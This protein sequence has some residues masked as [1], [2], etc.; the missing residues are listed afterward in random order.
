MH[1]KKSVVLLLI[2]CMFLSSSAFAAQ[3]GDYT[4]TESGGN[5]TITAYTGAGGAISIP[6]TLGGYPTVAIGASAFFGKSTIT[7]VTI[8]DSVTSIGGQAFYNCSGMTSVSISASVISIGSQAFM[9]CS[10]LT[11]ITVDAGNPNYS[12][13]DDVLYNNP[14]TTLIQFPGGKSGAFIIPGSVTS[15]GGSAFLGCSYLTNVSISASVISIGSYAFNYCYALTTITVDAGNPNYSSLDGV[16]Y[17]NTRTTLIQFPGGKSGAFIIP[18]SVTSIVDYAF[19]GCNDMTIIRIPDS[20]TSIGSRAFASCTGLTG[21]NIPDS[22]TNIG[23]W[24]FFGCSNLTG[25]YF[26]GNAPTMGLNVFLNCSSGFTVYYLAGATGFTNPWYGYPTAVFT[27]TGSLALI[28]PNGGES[29][30]RNSQRVITWSASGCQGTL[31][32]T[33]WQNGGLIG[34][35]VDDVNPVSG[36]YSWVV[37]NYIGGTAP[38]G[39]GYAI[40]I[41]DN[42]SSLED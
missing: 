21:M 23:G 33:L 42:G 27:P 24:A 26:Y 28:K 1:L 20:V 2:G 37:G 3:D 11:T 22:V 34:T 36:S 4:Y 10:V 40:K 16:L 35:I 12:S 9:L 17:N 30:N 5:A 13:L 25:A 32:L 18:G 31:K 39:T 8:P 6:A 15:I 7:S 41:E 14:R 29:W 38:L 19:A